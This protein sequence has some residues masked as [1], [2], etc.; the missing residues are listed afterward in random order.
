MS[1]PPDPNNPYGQQ[2]PPQPGYGYP[3]QPQPPQQ[4]GYAYPQQPQAGYAYPQGQPGYDPNAAAAY[5]Y[6]QQSPYGAMP[7]GTPQI[8]SMG[9]R[10]GARLIDGVLVGVVYSIVMFA[11]VAGAVGLGS[12]A[13]TQ[14]NPTT[15]QYELSQS[16]SMGLIGT[17]MVT[18]LVFAVLSLC[19]EWLMVAFAGGTLGKK[20]VGLRVVNE[21]TGQNP[22]LGASFVRYIIPIV[23]WAVCYLPG[24][25]VWLS[26]FFDNSGRQQGWHDKA[27]HTLVIRK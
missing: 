23:G 7:Y 9:A 12:K 15:G 16:A 1:Y 20:M 8:A 18:F 10:F 24:L 26:P 3:Q 19:Y 5:G 2:P 27:A 11:G 17:M 25:L 21:T 6:P 13:E 22:G 14:Y 4:P